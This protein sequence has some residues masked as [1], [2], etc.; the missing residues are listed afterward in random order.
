MALFPNWS[1]GHALPKQGWKKLENQ[2]PVGILVFPMMSPSDL[3]AGRTVPKL[4]PEACLA[5]ARLEKVG[6]TGSLSEAL[7]FR[8]RR[9]QVWQLIALFP[10]RS[11]RHALPKPGWKKLGK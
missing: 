9:H 7:F 2:L 4:V 10:N 3:A 6:K 1:L 5:Q 11:L 8:W